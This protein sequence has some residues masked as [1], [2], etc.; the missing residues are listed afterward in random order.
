MSS[1]PVAS[2]DQTKPKRLRA[3]ALVPSSSPAA[4]P[5]PADLVREYASKL[6]GLRP[7]HTLSLTPGEE[8]LELRYKVPNTETA[9]ANVLRQH[10]LNQYEVIGSTYSDN[11]MIALTLIPLGKSVVTNTLRAKGR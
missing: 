8:V 4:I 3:V 1:S 7:F 6:A 2:S 10:D 11:D 9:I 5:Q